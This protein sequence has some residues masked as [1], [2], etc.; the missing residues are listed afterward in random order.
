M[1]FVYFG[2]F[3]DNTVQQS[4]GICVIRMAMRHGINIERERERE[5]RE[6]NLK[7]FQLYTNVD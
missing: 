6:V 2:E 4:N 7:Q 3:S 1:Q 5:G